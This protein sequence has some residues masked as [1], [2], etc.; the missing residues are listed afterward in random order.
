V[1][2]GLSSA[3]V[4]A[5]VLAPLQAFVGDLH[6]VNT[7]EHQ[8]AK[9]AAMEA[10]WESGPG[11]PLTLF[12]LPDE[13]ARE[14]HFEISIPKLGSLIATRDPNGYVAGLNDFVGEHPPVAPVFWGF[15]V[16][17]GIGMLMIGVAGLGV[18]L[19]WKRRQL[20]PLYLKLLLGMTFS[21]WVATVA[22]WYVTEIG[23]QPWLV[24]GVLKTKDAVAHLPSSHVGMN[25]TAYLVTYAFLL[26]AYIGSLFYLANREMATE[27]RERL[28]S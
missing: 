1:R 8:P 15:R 9:L 21:G 17:V 3:I 11:M 12:A 19:L 22:G 23:R 16:M 2:S 5:A 6:G 25:F 24:Y 10:H 7:R 26:L 14:N 4:L 20:P 27:P 18:W 28:K 13:T